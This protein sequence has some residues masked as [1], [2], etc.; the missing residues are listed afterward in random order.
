VRRVIP[1]L[2]VT[3]C[4][5]AP[6]ELPPPR[7]PTAKT[8]RTEIPRAVLS[9]RRPARAHVVESTSDLLGG[10][11]AEGRPGDHL[12]ENGLVAFVIG[13]P[14]R[15]LGFAD[16]GGQLLDAGM[17]GGEDALRQLFALTGPEFPRQAIYKK[18]ETEMRGDAAVVRV[19]GH[20]SSQK[21]LGIATEY[22]LQPGAR[23][24]EITTTFTNGGTATLRTFPVGDAVMWGRAERFVPEHG[25]LVPTAGP[26]E[27]TTST[28]WLLGVAPGVT[29]GY[30]LN[31]PLKAR[32]GIGW[33]DVTLGELTLDGGESKKV[34]RWL[35]V[36]A[37]PDLVLGEA[38]ASLRGETWARIG[39]RV[40]EE[41]G[42]SPVAGARLTLSDRA[43]RAVALA[44]SDA[45]GSWAQLAP[46]GDYLIAAEAPGR[47]GQQALDVKLGLGS[48]T[49]LDVIVSRP[50]TLRY[51]VVESGFESAARLT[52]LGVA[53]T[54]NPWLGHA[55]AS[56]GGNQL[57]TL[58]GRGEV[59]LPPGRYRV[60]ASR[61]PLFTVDEKE[62]EIAPGA[63]AEVQLTLQRA[64]DLPHLVCIDLHQHAEPSGDSSVS[65]DDRIAT[66]LAEGL[67]WAA[68]VD[69][70]FLSGD[71]TAALARLTRPPPFLAGV[72]ATRPG[73]GHFAVWPLLPRPA[74]ARGGAIDVRDKDA[75]QILAEL[76]AP[77]RVVQVNHA[78]GG[79]RG[80]FNL[81]G[82]HPQSPVLPRDWD[83]GFDAI[84]LWSGKDTARAD[85]VLAD[86][87]ALTNRG[88][89][90]TGVGGSDS[91]LV[92]G[93]EAGYP[94][95]CVF[96]EGGKTPSAL[97][98]AIKQRR[99][100]LVTNGPIV[101]VAVGGKGMGQIAP[102][103]RGKAR[104]EVE[105]RAAPWVDT[106]KLEVW[107]DGGRRGKP[108]DLPPG[109][110]AVRY[111]GAVDLKIEHDASVVVIVR[112]DASLE[113][114]LSRPEGAPPP[115]PL[116]VT[117]PIFLD[118][119]GDGR[120]T[121]PNAPPASKPGPTTKPLRP[122]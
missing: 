15:A 39:G 118:R 8:V 101:T 112:G 49:N 6:L 90:Y 42:G 102:A 111:Q 65:A 62:V 119:D 47:R 2:L 50:G 1:V 100:A 122:R 92:W 12:L 74:E 21:E 69:H 78:R 71:Y 94:R 33:S 97:V 88:L 22:V 41:G 9:K 80:Y 120:F 27:L 18:I 59:A 29:Y 76:R 75:H 57:H 121:A 28:G 40:V 93:Q 96:L 48:G 7:D 106:R 26:K 104:L 95:T 77:D 3:G 66:N 108:I 72:E 51:H 67:D 23:A 113:P 64:V 99:D 24:L 60:L 20:D 5:G 55:D 68:V 107:V 38:M 116:A 45:N 37:A 114:V 52:F 43:G 44:R 117:N 36:T 35:V 81:I 31:G 56:P 70:N 19:L 13:K 87:M 109:R 110:G 63:P 46:P 16:S 34:Q 30:L 79:A 105:V 53:P 84:E 115:L 54:R 91:H 61:G 14:D 98:Q 86:W 85:E 83:G 17:V 10:A 25:F 58:D 32:H 82:F 4:L 73:A 103:P 89:V 11:A